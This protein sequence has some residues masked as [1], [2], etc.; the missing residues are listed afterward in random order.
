MSSYRVLISDALSEQGV[1]ILREDKSIQVDVKLKLP[2][3]ELKKIIVDYDALIVRSGTQV[4]AD[5]IDSAKKLKVIGR[6]GAGLDNVDVEAASKRGI[7]VMNAAGGNTVS[8]AEHA[9]SLMM[10]MSRNIPQAC[11]SLKGGKWERTKYQ[12][13]ELYRKTLGIIGL[14]RIGKEVA[15]RAMAFGMQ[16]IAFDPFLSLGKIQEMEIEPASLPEILKRADYITVHTPMTDETRHMI[17]DKEFAMMKKGVRIINCA[18]GGIIEEQALIRAIKAGTVAAASLDVFE[19]EPPQASLELLKMDQVVVTPHLGASTE[20]AQLSVAVD[21]AAGVRD[22]LL[23]RGIRNAVNVPSVD[24]ELYKILEPYLRLAEALGSTQAQMTEGH[25]QEVR[26][27]YVGDLVKYELAPL[28]LSFIKGLLTP[29]LQETVN[30][31]NAAI[32][33]RERGI[34]VIESKSTESEDFATL[35]STEVRTDRAKLRVD[36]AF[37]TRRDPRIVRI[38]EFYVEALPHGQ[39]VIIRTKDQPGF[40]GKIG[41]ILGANGVNIG[42]MTFGRTRAGG[43]ALNVFNVD[44]LVTPEVLKKIKASLDPSDEVRLIKL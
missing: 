1:K 20:E 44:G 30:Y 40:I 2:P 35:I 32:L 23:G 39:M 5:L 29:S 10:S 25:M 36:G 31:V 13:V 43:E 22:A 16:V 37:V 12:G 19:E 42:R 11:A 24:G 9:F 18:R 6:A 27:R 21:I 33:A 7:I 17:S 4:T 8:T 41:T 26:V 15:K 28:T 3:A 14:G 38:D 34:K